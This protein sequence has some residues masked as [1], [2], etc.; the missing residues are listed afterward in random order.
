MWEFANKGIC[1]E[2]RNH[3]D[4]SEYNLC[5]ISDIL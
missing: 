3:T 1:I 4:I 2:C 5:E